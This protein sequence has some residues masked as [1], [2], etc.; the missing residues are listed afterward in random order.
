MAALVALVLVGRDRIAA[1]VLRSVQ[2][3]PQPVPTSVEQKERLRSRLLT[4]N[5]KLIYHRDG[6]LF[7]IICW[8][9]AEMTATA[10][11]AVSEPH[12]S[13]TKQG[14]DTIKVSFDPALRRVQRATIHEQKC[15]ENARQIFLSQVLPG[16]RKWMNGERDSELLQAVIG[17]LSRFNLSEAELNEIY[18]SLLNDRPLSFR[19][20][21][22]VAP[23][24]YSQSQCVSLFETYAQ[25]TPLIDDRLGDTFPLVDIRAWF[26]A[27]AQKV[28][29][30]IEAGHV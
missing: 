10:N 11:E 4:T 24:P 14:L 2:A 19:A 23:P 29:S 15:S 3:T 6:L 26:E 5:E 9:V 13:S 21:L 18:D 12:L 17:L 20:A 27:F 7:E 22:T 1:F 16:F 28:W 8:I 25:L 30:K